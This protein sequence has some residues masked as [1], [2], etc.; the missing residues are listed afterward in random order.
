MGAS[1]VRGLLAAAMVL[2]M[3]PEGIRSN[4]SR[5]R[6]YGPKEPKKPKYPFT[7]EELEKLSSFTNIKEKK[8]YLKELKEKYENIN[9]SIG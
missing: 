5:L 3:Q 1:N 7:E 2:S 6:N 9:R 8:V 4:P